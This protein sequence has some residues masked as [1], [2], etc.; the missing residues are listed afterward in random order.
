MCLIKD[1]YK[2]VSVVADDG[3]WPEDDSVE[4]R[5]EFAVIAG[6]KFEAAD[7]CAMRCL[8]SPKIKPFIQFCIF[9]TLS[10]SWC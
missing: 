8:F 7:D 9:F 3:E 10:Q 6:V 4:L 5:D 1:R 2:P